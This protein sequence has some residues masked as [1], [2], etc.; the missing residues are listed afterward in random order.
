MR[1]GDIG[2]SLLQ[3]FYWIVTIALIFAS[4]YQKSKIN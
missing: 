2:A 1:T 4:L 3:A